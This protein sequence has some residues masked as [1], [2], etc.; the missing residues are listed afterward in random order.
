MASAGL[1]H[2]FVGVVY[3]FTHPR[4]R[5]KERRVGLV[6]GPRRRNCRATTTVG[7]SIERV[8]AWDMFVNF[9]PLGEA[10]IRLVQSET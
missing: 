10:F 5:L 8:L 4:C 3:R 7:R 9:E 6:G 1:I 2:R